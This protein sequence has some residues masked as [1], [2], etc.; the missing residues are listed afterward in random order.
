MTSALPDKIGAMQS[1]TVPNSPQQ[2]TGTA[3]TS[4]TVSAP[5]D[6]PSEGTSPGTYE[7]ASSDTYYAEKGIGSFQPGG[8]N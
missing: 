4:H 6:C 7:P 1:V 3:S 2:S 8:G 5:Q